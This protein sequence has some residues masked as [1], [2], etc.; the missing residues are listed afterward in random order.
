MTQAETTRLFEKPVEDYLRVMTASP[1]VALAD[2]ATNVRILSDVYTQAK[3][4]QAELLVLPELAVS[5]YST[6]D[7]FFNRH[8]LDKTEAALNELAKLT[9]DGPAIV[10]GAP[11]EQNGILYNCAVVL[12][13]GSVQGVVPKTFLPNY[14]EFY[15]KRWFTSGKDITGRD[16]RLGGEAVPFGTDLLFDINGTRVGVEVCEDGWAAISPG[17][18]AALQGAEVIVNLSASNESI[19]KASFRRKLVTDHASRLICAYVY[20]SAGRGESVADTV[21]GGHQLLA[22]NGRLVDEVKPLRAGNLVYDIDREYLLADRTV[23]KTYGD[24]AA[25]ERQVIQ[26]RIIDI[27]VPRPTDGRLLRHVEGRPFGNPEAC[28]E[29]F[30]IISQGLADRLEDIG[31]KATVLGL[32]GGLDSTLAI[33]V[34]AEARRKLGKPTSFVHSIGM[35]GFASSERTQDNAT[36]LAEALGSTHKIMPIN[37]I[38]EQFMNTIGHDGETEDI[39]YENIQARTRTEI[40]MNYANMV[41]GMVQGTGDLSESAQGW[42]TYNG[43]HMSMY[44]PNANVFKTMA[45][46]MVRWYADNK[47][48]DEVKAVL[49]DILNTPISPELTGNGDLSQTTEDIIGPYELTEFFQVELQRRKSSP[50]KIGYLATQASFEHTYT[51][52]EIQHWLNSFLDRY[53]SSQWKRDVAPNG[54]Q[55]G[56]IGNSPR[57]QLRLPPNLSRRWKD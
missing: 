50:N 53:T 39:T 33:L 11:I 22:E 13:E 25:A 46:D 24:E 17:T 31:A 12:A 20:T 35:P 5:G 16:I 26:F 44:N 19:G 23:N 34:A 43:D 30:D 36:Q 21:W 40:L 37:D 15:E 56:S 48:T 7:L 57:T 55:T 14:N 18:H 29:A 2:P 38:S 27:S 1:D 54:V 42:C 4:E 9:T 6:A 41:G 8:V 52:E 10:A 47:A 51:E 45:K 3:Q 32:S 28:A 49:Y